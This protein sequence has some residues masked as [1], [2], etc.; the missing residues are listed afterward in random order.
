MAKVKNITGDTLS[1]F[2]SDAPPC[3]P[4]G[5]VEVRDELFVGR[6]W[7]TST[8]E[9]V[10]PPALEGYEDRSTEDA[11]LWAEEPEDEPEKALDD[12][13]VAEL[14]AHAEAAGIDLGGA[15]TKADIRAAIENAEG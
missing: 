7:P 1:L 9:L 11:H 4:G 2:R 5:E 3:D 13:T 10:E 8:W 15:T 14:K 12:M 6:A